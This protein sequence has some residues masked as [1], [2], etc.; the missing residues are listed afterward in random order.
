MPGLRAERNVFRYR[1]LPGGVAVRI[2]TSVSDSERRL[3]E[4]AARTA[5]ARLVWSHAD[6]ETAEQFATRLA[7][8]G[9]DRLRLL[10]DGT[11][12]DHTI[13]RAAH[14]LGVAVDDS[15]PVGAPEIELPRWLREQSVTVTAHR[16]GRVARVT[17]AR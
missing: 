6:I 9:V 14:G 4:L 8:L 7:T 3:V 16:H 17:V 1:R 2:G 5:G 10:G 12:V 13:L 15:P 11:D